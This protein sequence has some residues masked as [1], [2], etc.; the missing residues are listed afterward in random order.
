MVRRSIIADT[1]SARSSIHAGCSLIRLGDPT[2]N[3]TKAPAVVR[4]PACLA[5]HLIWHVATGRVR[6]TTVHPRQA[7]P[8]DH[9]KHLAQLSLFPYP[10][11]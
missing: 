8:L 4:S 6:M 11:P 5:Q 10:R 9:A 2:K 3:P 1:L 7:Y